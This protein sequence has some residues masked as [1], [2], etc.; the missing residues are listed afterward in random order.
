MLMTP[1]SDNSSHFINISDGSFSPIRSFLL[2]L[3]TISD[4]CGPISNSILSS[5]MIVPSNLYTLVKSFAGHPFI[6][7]LIT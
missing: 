2:R 1:L 7:S 6:I 3:F 5:K 4:V